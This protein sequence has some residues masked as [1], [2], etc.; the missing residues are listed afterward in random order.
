MRIRFLLFASLCCALIINSTAQQRTT[1][2][3]KSTVPMTGLAKICAEP[4]SGEELKTAWPQAPVYLL[5]KPPNSK[6]WGTK[7]PI[8]LPG[9]QAPTPASAR[10]LVC[11]QEERLETGSYESGA[12]AYSPGWDVYL[13]RLPDHGIYFQKTGIF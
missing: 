9:M 4:Y 13:I 8:K 2:S 1:S 3:R 12:K 7:A 11:V 5:F 10:T 6:V